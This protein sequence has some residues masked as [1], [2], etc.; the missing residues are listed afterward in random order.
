MFLKLTSGL[1]VIYLLSQCSLAFLLRRCLLLHRSASAGCLQTSSVLQGWD[2]CS[3][4]LKEARHKEQN[5]CPWRE[6]SAGS[7]LSCWLWILPSR[8][9]QSGTLWLELLGTCWHF[10][11]STHEGDLRELGPPDGCGSAG[12]LLA[13]R[14][15][16]GLIP[17]QGMCQG[18]RFGSWMGFT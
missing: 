8:L 16:A 9:L 4:V 7:Y 10:W 11:F 2:I 14:K 13:Q 1:S 3:Q 6:P 15:E 18:C 17:M 5:Q 12:D